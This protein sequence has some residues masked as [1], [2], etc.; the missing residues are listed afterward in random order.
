MKILNE[1]SNIFLR[2]D[3]INQ[4]WCYSHHIWFLINQLWFQWNLHK[5]TIY[6]MKVYNITVWEDWV[7]DD[8]WVVAQRIV[9]LEFHFNFIIIISDIKFDEISCS[10]TTNTHVQLISFTY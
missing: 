5:Q 7:S 3:E 8:F 2:T 1:I 6:S 9:I 4:C 10:S